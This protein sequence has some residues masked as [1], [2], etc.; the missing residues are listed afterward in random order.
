MGCHSSELEKWFMRF[1]HDKKIEKIVHST[2]EIHR[3]NNDLLPLHKAIKKSVPQRDVKFDRQGKFRYWFK[4]LHCISSRPENTKSLTELC[5]K[6]LSYTCATTKMLN[7]GQF[8]ASSKSV[9]NRSAN[10]I[11]LLK[12]STVIVAFN[13]AY[14]KHKIA[15]KLSENE[16][17]TD[18]SWSYHCQSSVYLIKKKYYISLSNAFTANESFASRCSTPMCCISSC[19]ENPSII[20]TSGKSFH[21]WDTRQE[22]PVAFCN[23]ASSCS[24][25]SKLEAKSCCFVQRNEHEFVCIDKEGEGRLGILDKRKLNEY[26]NTTETKFKSIFSLE[27]NYDKTILLVQSVSGKARI[28]D[29]TSFSTI[30]TGYYGTKK[31]KPVR[32]LAFTDDF[33]IQCSENLTLFSATF[34]RPLLNVPSSQMP[35]AGSAGAMSTTFLGKPSESI[36][37]STGSSAFTVKFH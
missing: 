5:S 29:Q 18:F 21:I 13:P 34:C 25:L 9:L 23:L 15:C 30:H 7:D 36:I 14:G 8:S 35:L 10:F 11:G 19:K 31:C 24:R 3:L 37:C 20:L 28:L 26:S 1:C 17:V 4:E 16:S 12:N 27:E 32:G 2:N 22:G 6:A 33:F